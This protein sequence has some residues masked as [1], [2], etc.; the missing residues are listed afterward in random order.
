MAKKIR[1]LSIPSNLAFERKL[2]FSDGFM[3]G[4]IW[5]DEHKNSIR[6]LKVIEKAIRGTVSNRPNEASK[7]DP[8]KQNVNLDSPNLHPVDASFLGMEE[9]TVVV[10]YTLKVLSGLENPSV[11]NDVDFEKAVKTIVEDYKERTGFEELSFRYAYNIANARSLWRNRCGAEKIDVVVQHED[12]KFVFNAYDYSTKTFDNHTENVK[13]LANI[14]ADAL[15]GKRPY[16]LLKVTIYA[17][18]GEGQEVFP[19]EE[20]IFNKET[21]E[22]R[23]KSKVLYSVDDIAAMHSQKIGNAIRCIDTWYP[24]YDA[25][26]NDSPIPAEPYG[27][28]TTR[29]AVFRH[30][31]TQTDFYTIFDKWALGEK[32]NNIEEEHFVMAVLIRGGVFGKAKEKEKKEKKEK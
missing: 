3:F 28:V 20:L 25:D 17:K 18:I 4:T 13:D 1:E 12:E 15:S 11:C 30:P 2:S 29:G 8:T 31:D 5:D 21:K 22:E 24:S 7:D 32:P 16:A 19:S 27:V 26:N 23:D 10:K 14:I 9:D 6:P